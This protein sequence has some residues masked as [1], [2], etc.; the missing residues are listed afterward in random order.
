MKKNISL[1]I[2]FLL[3]PLLFFALIDFSRETDIWFLFSHGRYVL[4]HGFPHTEFLTIHKGFE[5]VM[6][7][8][9]FS[10][11]IYL[12]YKYIGSIGV[13]SFVG[14]VNILIIFF[15]YKLCMLISSNNK[16][17]S[18]LFAS[19]IDLL[20][21]LSFIIPR[22]QIVSILLFLILIYILERY[23]RADCKSKIIYFIPLLS[24]V[25]INFHASMWGVLFILCLPYIVELFI[26]FIRDKN[27]KFLYLITVLMI[28]FLVGFINP[29]GY[30][31]MFYV[32]NSYGIKLINELVLE[33]SP[34]NI[35]SSKTIIVYYSCLY[36]VLFIVQMIIMF[37]NR[38]RYSLHVFLLFFGLVIMSFLSIRSV[39]IYLVCSAPFIIVPIKRK[40]YSTVSVSVFL[41]FVFLI[42]FFYIHNC[43][44][45]TY[46]LVDKR[47]NG[48]V[49]YIDR[50]YDINVRI[51]N[52]YDDGP[53][54]EY[55][56]YKPYIDTR[57]EV[58]IKKM[59]KKSDVFEE[60]VNVNKG[61]ID[62]DNFI[63]KYNFKL[64]VVKYDSYIYKY[65][66]E[67]KKYVIVYHD[68][69]RYIFE[70]NSI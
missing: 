20:L 5:F 1:G 49:S 67:N 9:G 58:F 44:A 15:L 6:Q 36:I 65:L 52:D 51:Y 55:H 32:F 19:V 63:D 18:F 56:N 3:L 59:N 4:S 10:I 17:F 62:Y 14:L 47:M 42:L 40:F 35:F 7:Q 68:K 29:Y 60:Y 16:Y 54:L 22:P 50:N 41:L 70:K 53:Y 61:N 46:K 30:K 24:I 57:A 26:C 66:K 34:I 25:L 33:M 27:K 38:K 37:I 12:L 31:A 28:S 8:S 11:I 64:F 69:Y 39:S 45:G 21:E 48:V 13:I 23:L 2:V 43:V